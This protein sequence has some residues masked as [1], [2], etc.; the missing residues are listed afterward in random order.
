MKQQVN[1]M[2]IDIIASYHDSIM[3]RFDET[4]KKINVLIISPGT[5]YVWSS[6]GR[7]YSEHSPADGGVL[8]VRISE[9]EILIGLSEDELQK[10]RE[11]S[12]LGENQFPVSVGLTIYP[13]IPDPAHNM[14]SLSFQSDDE[15]YI[16]EIPQG[17]EFVAIPIYDYYPENK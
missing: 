5:N 16:E 7:S 4:P 3:D 8:G 15:S 9:D 1:A 11:D 2:I 17:K 12:D 14:G 6:D 13:R 10:L